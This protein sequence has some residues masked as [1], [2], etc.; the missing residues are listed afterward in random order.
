MSQ[1][2]YGLGVWRRA[3][4]DPSE[5]YVGKDQQKLY[6]HRTLDN[7]AISP[8]YLRQQIDYFCPNIKDTSKSWEFTK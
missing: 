6:L 4:V 2:G 5:Y 1:A 3:D 7:R 8:A